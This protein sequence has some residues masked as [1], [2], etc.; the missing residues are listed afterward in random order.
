MLEK[1]IVDKVLDFVRQQPRTVQEIAS[2]LDR[3]WRTAERYVDA[4]SQET[5]MIATRTFRKGTRGAL[6][7]VF[8]NALEPGKGSAF[9][10]LLLQRIIA[11]R[12]KEDFSPFDIYQF[13]PKERR[14]AFIEEHEFSIQKKIKFDTLLDQAQ[15]QLLMFS[16]NLS[17]VELGPKM[18]E[19]LEALAKRG[20]KIKVLTR[21]DITSEH[22]TR[23]MMDLNLRAGKDAVEIRHCEQPLRAVIID[24]ALA[25]IKEV[26]SPEIVRE[27]KTKKFIFYKITDQQWIMWLQKVF[28][29]L[30]GQSVDAATRLEALSTIEKLSK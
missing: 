14:E 30:W 11:G 18:M 5:G 16:G 29:H 12:K 20:V 26:M 10:E 7:V 6:K 28:W 25:S 17:W 3:N 19:T 23:Q 1:E 22:N 4:I 21:V 15:Q 8:W 27:L 13:V 9:Q 2:L 24:D